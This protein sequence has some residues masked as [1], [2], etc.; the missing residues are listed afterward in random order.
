MI[1]NI[2]KSFP[3]IFVFALILYN[4]SLYFTHLLEM[5]VI[6]NSDNVYLPMLYKSLFILN[7]NFSDWYGS[8]APYYFPDMFLY[9]FLMLITNGNYYLSFYL[10]F[11]IE[12]IAIFITIFFIY[13]LFFNKFISLY[14]SLIILGTIY[15]IPSL[16]LKYQYMSVFH[17]G[18]FVIGLII[19]YLVLSNFN[20]IIKIKLFIVFI[21]TTI[22][23]LSDK[24]LILH[25]IFPIIITLI[26]LWIKKDITSKLLT[27]V[28]M[29]FFMAFISSKI[30]N[31]VIAVHNSSYPLT[32]SYKNI[33]ENLN[34]ISGIFKISFLEYT[35]SSILNLISIVFI[36]LISIYFFRIK[37]SYKFVK[38]QFFLFYSIIMIIG[39]IFALSL[40]NDV[41]I[42]ER[43]MI[44]VF[45]IPIICIPIIYRL[46][47]NIIK[48]ENVKNI[49]IA[50]TVVLFISIS[51]S[52]F[53]NFKE[54]D[55]KTEYYPNISSCIDTFLDKNNLKYGISGYWQAKS[56]NLLSKKDIFISQVKP[57]LEPYLHVIN[58]KWYRNIYDFALIE[59]DSPLAAFSPEKEKILNLNGNPTEIVKCE[60][61]EILYYKN[62]LITNV[63]NVTDWFK[64][65]KSIFNENVMFNS[66]NILFDGWSY[67]ENEFRWSLNNESNII[68]KID[69]NYN[70]IQ[71]ILEINFLTYDKQKIILKLN[72]HDLGEYTFDSL[73]EKLVVHFDLEDLNFE[74]PNIL[75]F[76]LPTAKKPSSEDKRI[77]ALALKSFKIK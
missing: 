59:Y 49:L 62:G 19:V 68:F 10:F 20:N 11:T 56:I 70:Y 22:T 2:Y 50:I 74:T 12:L 28:A 58:S 6:Y 69:K 13:K 14:F 54:K 44:P 29:V 8:P 51:Y 55:L 73:D 27:N 37:N 36:I 72:G 18:E 63:K 46:F 41:P 1:K 5:N 38:I 52:T 15:Y 16:I 21:L 39:N 4:A 57:N 42:N 45:I 23:I 31:Y 77:L 43:Y 71:G 30:I 9:F 35:F 53:N 64:E 40:I 17:F 24:M 33:L 67:P 75:Q 32:F 7:E 26:F 66:S 65:S 48:E 76:I 3:I 61:I 60:N 25:F 34:T 47:I